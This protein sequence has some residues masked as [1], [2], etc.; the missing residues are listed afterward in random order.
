VILTKKGREYSMFENAEVVKEGIWKYSDSVECKVRVI[1]WNILYGTGDYEDSPELSNDREVECYYVL[2]ESI[3]E[4][5]RFPISRGGFLTIQE[6]MEDAESSTFQK[7][8]WL[9]ID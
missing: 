9:K 8:E 5:G 7:I 3:V 2:Q 4:K 6:A 1:K